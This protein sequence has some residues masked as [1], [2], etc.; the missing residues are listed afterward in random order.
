MSDEIN[1]D[2]ILEAQLDTLEDALS[3]SADETPELILGKYKDMDEAQ[4]GMKELEKKFHQVSAENAALREKTELKQVLEKMTEMSSSKD[5]T[6]DSV[7]RLNEEFARIAD[8]FREDPEEGVKKMSS[9]MNAW[10]IDEGRKVKAET[11]KEV[12]ELRQS[13]SELRESM[14]NMN[15]DYI[16]NKELVDELVS[17]GMAKA[18]AIDWAKKMKGSSRVLPTSL[19]GSR[20]RESEKKSVYLTKEDRARMKAYD[21]LTDEDLDMLEASYQERSRRGR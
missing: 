10:I 15:P 17:D 2:T 13:L 12:S 16:E 20:I 5:S 4:K 9:L 14:G 1:E 18:K 7:E 3:D 6:D 11:S 21:G 19:S 8:D